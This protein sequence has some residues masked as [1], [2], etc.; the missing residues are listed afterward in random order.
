[1]VLRDFRGTSDLLRALLQWQHKFSDKF[2]V[3]A[4]LSNQYYTLNGSNALEPRI[5]ARLALTQWQ[6]LSLGA[7]LHSQMQPAY[8]YF[9][10]HDTLGRRIETN[11]ELDFTRAAHA[12]VAYDNTFAE[13]FRLKAEVYYQKLYRVPVHAFA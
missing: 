6:S 3:N 9:A 5:G 7:G 12:V 1:V 4:G 8:I 10:S 11:R 2:T 13:L